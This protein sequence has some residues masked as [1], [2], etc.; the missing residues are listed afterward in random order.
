[1]SH[2]KEKGVSYPPYE[3][4]PFS[5]NQKMGKKNFRGPTFSGNSLSEIETKGLSQPNRG[6]K[7]L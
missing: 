3:I 1:M 7:A 4:P 2:T 5:E 6:R